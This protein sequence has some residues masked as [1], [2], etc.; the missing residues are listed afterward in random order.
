MHNNNDDISIRN[1][2]EIL[3]ILLDNHYRSITNVSVSLEPT[4]AGLKVPLSDIRQKQEPYL[5]LA[6]VPCTRRPWHWFSKR[7]YRLYVRPVGPC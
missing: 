5:V 2:T 6:T 4:H 1:T 7:V 3:H